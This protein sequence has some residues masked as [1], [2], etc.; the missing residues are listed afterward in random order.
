MGY[1]DN[2]PCLDSAAPNEPIFVGLGRDPLAAVMT[3]IWA[4]LSEDCQPAGQIR[5]ARAH[6][7]RMLAYCQ[8]RTPGREGRVTPAALK[9]AEEFLSRMRF[10]MQGE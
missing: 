4:E 2:D 9:R 3:M 7:E 1:I 8:R 10:E 5:E 6:A